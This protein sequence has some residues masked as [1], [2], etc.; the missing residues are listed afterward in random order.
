MNGSYETGRACALAVAGGRDLARV[1]ARYEGLFPPEAFDGGLYASLAM[2]G[3]FAA[4]WA[5]ASGLRAVNRASLLVFAVDRLIDH[6]AAERDEVAALVADCLAAAGGEPPVSPAARFTA[7]LREELASSPGFPVLAAAWRDQLGRMLAAMA[8][9]WDWSHGGEPPAL[10]EYLDNAAGTGAL[11]VGVTHW[12]A[13]G[14]VTAPADLDRLREPGDAVQRYLRLLNDLATH[15]RE[16]AYGDVNAFT[17]GLS[18]D[19]VTARMAELADRAEAL[20]EPLRA[21]LPRAAE[22]LSWQLHYSTGFYGL[23]DFWAGRDS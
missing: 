6:E 17:L 20:I 12:I 21:D 23:S 18:G 2:A 10:A 7:G 9:E 14:L 8:R 19:E 15:G 16:S 3:A 1:A 11:F 4:P 22:Y 13:T 5:G